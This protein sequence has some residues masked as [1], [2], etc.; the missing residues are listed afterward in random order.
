MIRKYIPLILILLACAPMMFIHSCAN[1]TQAPT[2]GKKDTI[3]PSIVNIIPL[4][5]ATNAP[6]EG[7]KVAFEFNEYVTIKD[8]KNIFISPPTAKAP[9]GK[10]KGKSLVVS[11][12]DTLLPETTYTISINDAV[13]DN[14]EGNPYPGF[15]YVFST[16]DRIDSMAIT[17]TVLD[18][19]TLKPVKGATVLLYKDHSDSAV[20][21]HR[22]DAA[23]RT[24][25]WGYFMIPFIQDTLYRLYALLDENSDNKYSPGT[26][27]IGFVSEPVR[28]T[29]VVSDT[30]KEFKKYMMD[31]T[32]G[33]TARLSQY[34]IKLFKENPVK[35][36]LNNRVR[37]SDRLA[38]ITF[39]SRDTWIDSLWIAGYPYESVIT[40]FNL[41]Q[42]SL[43]IWVN[44][45]RLPPDTLDIWV[46]YRKSDTAGGFTPSLEKARVYIEGKKKMSS[47]ERTKNLQHKDTICNFKL[48]A[49]GDKVEQKG[50]ELEFDLPIIY[51]NFDSVKMWAINPR[52]QEEPLTFDV[53]AD[54]LDIRRYTIRPRTTYQAG[55]EYF[56]K[57]PDKCFQDI[58]G[59][60]SDSTRTSVSLPN[61]PK[62]GSIKAVLTEVNTQYIV[63]LLDEKLT[64]VM[65]SYTIDKD[66][67][68][69]FPYLGAGK[70]CLRF[71]RDEN[72]NLLV[73]S[74][75]LLEHKQPEAVLFL[76]KNDD[77][78]IEL[79][80]GFNIE[81]RVNLQNMFK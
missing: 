40:Q 27:L 63:D 18:C 35:Q 22:P 58:G 77:T 41:D 80:E 64:N 55:Y 19:N 30:L 49:S 32:L 61:D 81:E 62:L 10:I 59:F 37:V 33:C 28:P 21:L 54:S 26:E 78:L 74:G 13:G 65:R 48:T 70:Y 25:D 66:V 12:P 51:E 3:P 39:S 36:Y 71:T 68:L 16:G 42:D 52:Q 31:D 43:L 46:N 56:I 23:I 2:G 29:L 1:T 38:Y 6:L 75:I 60:W 15:S 7:M 20:F 76:K 69:L 57:I 73:D 24:D 79:E 47:Y 50:F 4:P 17:G 34:E 45:Q 14:N 8:A 67:T 44:D 9:Q 11:I 53:E 72:R 5:G